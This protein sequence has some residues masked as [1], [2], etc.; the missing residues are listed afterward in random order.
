MNSKS[1]KITVLLFILISLLLTVPVIAH[2]DDPDEEETSTEV[3]EDHSETE[4][5]DTHTDEDEGEDHSDSEDE[6]TSGTSNTS[7]VIGGLIGATLLAA[8]AAFIFSPRPGSMTL[9]GLALIGAT[10]AI[11]IMVGSMWGDTLLLLNGIGFL[12]LGVLWAMPN[13]FIPN[14]KRILAIVLALYTLVTIL[15]YFLTHDHYDFVAILTKVIEVP[16]LIILAAAA[17][18]SPADA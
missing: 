1:K 7:F 8:G 5:E 6:H 2:G 4:K 12:G 14:Q 13:Q 16:L 9:I 15:G 18:Q 3:S 17:L 10:G 11:H